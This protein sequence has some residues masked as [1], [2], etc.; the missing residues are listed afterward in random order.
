MLT[1]KR[2]E[3]QISNRKGKDLESISEKKDG[4]NMVHG[5]KT[6]TAGA[7]TD[8]DEIDRIMKEIED[9]EKKIDVPSAKTDVPTPEV[10]AEVSTE[11]KTQD[12]APL[13]TEAP[14][15][16]VIEPD[17]AKVVPIRPT[18]GESMAES[19]AVRVNDEPLMKTES[20]TQESGSLGLKVGGCATV[21]LEFEKAGVVIRLT[22]SDSG[23][24]ISTD[25]G[26]EFRI[27]LKSAA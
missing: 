8:G 7:M 19:D 9:L 24:V 2:F 6:A 13:Q 4:G 14:E 26:A 11:T 21:S 22:C 18:M 1:Q 17:L 23:L 20:E 12:N 3:S 25:Q 27:P 5:D 10:S 15:E 16:S